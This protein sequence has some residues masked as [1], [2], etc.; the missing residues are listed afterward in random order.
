M[1]VVSKIFL[2]TLLIIILVVLG[3]ILKKWKKAKKPSIWKYQDDIV[4]EK[5]VEKQDD[6]TEKDKPAQKNY[7]AAYN[8]FIAMHS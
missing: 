5:E 7:T 3:C 4:I 2:F 8:P 6:D 1:N